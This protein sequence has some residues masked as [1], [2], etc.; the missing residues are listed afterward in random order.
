MAH[1]VFILGAGFSK[2][3]S[4]HMPTMK[5]LTNQVSRKLQIGNI[6]LPPP[7]KDPQN[8]SD[9]EL[10]N[11]IELW[12]TFL[13]QSQPWIEGP[14]N[15]A[16]HSITGFI[17]RY[18]ND[19]IDQS[20]LSTMESSCV[21]AEDSLR[22]PNWLSLLIEA[23]HTRQVSVITLNYDT[24][25]ERAALS[26][27]DRLEGDPD[28][29]PINV[30][31]RYFSHIRSRTTTL[32]SPSRTDTFKLFKLHGSVNWHYSGR[33]DFFGET[34][35]F[36]DVSPWGAIMEGE[37]LSRLSSKDKEP[38]IIP[39]VMEKTTYFNNESVR[40]LWREASSA[41]EQAENVYVIGYSLPMSD[42]GMQFF[43]K[44]SLPI[45][46]TTWYI[47]NPDTGIV[48][49]YEKLLAPDQ[50]VDHRYT[51]EAAPVQRFVEEYCHREM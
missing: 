23:W 3:I 20:T 1:D 19:I 25:V 33:D 47:V 41:L 21:F 15:E 5:E 29:D 37:A 50:I 32:L 4:G 24:L 30:Y 7:L 9:R 26:I 35:Y 18:I 43:L 39:P 48:S 11:N 17:R 44:Q 12:M 28:L 51:A 31:P 40:R 36:S 8:D 42:L 2:A 14:F 34:I 22:M 49:H 45:K 6:T 16:N 10:E 46:E 27:A 13:S 38:L